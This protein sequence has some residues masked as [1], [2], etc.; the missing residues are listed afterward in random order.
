M[1]LQIDP[2]HIVAD[3]VVSDVKSWLGSRDYARLVDCA[4]VPVPVI[5]RFGWDGS[6]IEPGFR[7]VR[8]IG[9][10]LYVLCRAALADHPEAR[11]LVMRVA[12]SLINYGI[13]PD[14]QFVCRLG[15]DGSVLDPAADLY[16]IAFGLFALA[17]WYRLSGDEA[18][19][20]CAEKVVHHLHETMRSPTGLGYRSRSDGFDGHEQNPH[21]HLLEA[22]IFLAKFSG[23]RVFHALA[24]ELFAL[25]E[26]CLFDPASGTLAER[27]DDQWQPV[28]DASGVIL[29]EPGHLYEWVWL[30]H[31]YAALSGCARP[32]EMADQLFLFARRYGH[33]AATGLVVDGVATDGRVIGPDLRNWPNTE[34]LKAQIAMRER[35]GN[36]PAFTARD[37]SDTV[38]RI[39]RYYLVPAGKTNNTLKCDLWIDY[40]K[41]NAVTPKCDHVP[42]SSLYHIVFGFSE[43]LRHMGEFVP[44]QTPAPFLL[45]NSAFQPLAAAGAGQ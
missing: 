37:L 40:L 22:A 11:H 12:K 16:D 30:L 33:D 23:R 24:A 17:W 1:T 34:F 41:A 6:A 5:E 44:N 38:A 2:D 10:Q 31:Q 4:E 27:F 9:R 26:R 3:N 25:A 21:M 36:G 18:V 35:Y 43:F 14:G 19:A 42:A 32:Y 13:G 7:R 15:P 8:V 28:S 39:F 45:A 20:E 29:I